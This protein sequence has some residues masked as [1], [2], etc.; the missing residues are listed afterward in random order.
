MI[1]VLKRNTEAQP[2]SFGKLWDVTNNESIDTPRKWKIK[3][4]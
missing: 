4:I 1:N 2:D 3:I